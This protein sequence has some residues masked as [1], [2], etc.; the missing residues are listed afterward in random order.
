MPQYC[1]NENAQ[2]NGD[3]EVHN[4][5]ANKTCLPALSNR[6]NLGEQTD[7]WAALDAAK[8]HFDDVDGCAYCTP[9]CHTS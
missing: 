1:V 3:H 6:R 5:T 9:A 8:R 2:A 7:C 4:V